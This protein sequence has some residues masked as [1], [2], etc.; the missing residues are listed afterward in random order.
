VR[1]K[2]AIALVVTGADEERTI[3]AVSPLLNDAE[4]AV[5]SSA[6]IALAHLGP[7]ARP[8]LPELERLAEDP[9]PEVAA[10]GKAAADR[11]REGGD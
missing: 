3:E 4:A 6:A 11:V 2:S 10:L 9:V 1:A 7:K 8:A 5:R